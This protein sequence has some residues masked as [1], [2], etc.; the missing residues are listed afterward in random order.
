MISIHPFRSVRHED[1][2]KIFCVGRD[3]DA[4]LALYSS[5]LALR[6]L[7]LFIIMGG[8]HGMALTYSG[9]FDFTLSAFGRRRVGRLDLTLLVGIGMVI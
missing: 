8:I 7:F 9:F 6:K 4:F 2:C 1:D 3:K 5:W